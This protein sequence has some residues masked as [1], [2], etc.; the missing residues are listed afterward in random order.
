MQ[1]IYGQDIREGRKMLSSYIFEIDD[2]LWEDFTDFF[3]YGKGYHD[4]TDEEIDDSMN[5]DDILEFFQYLF[6]QQVE[7]KYPVRV[8]LV[9]D[10]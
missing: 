3:R 4:W 10:N 2:T 8:R 1:K 9:K 5:D 7:T 6:R